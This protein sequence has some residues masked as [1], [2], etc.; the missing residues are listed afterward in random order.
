MRLFRA[1]ASILFSRV[2]Q[3]LANAAVVIMVAKTLGP[4]GQGHYSL[5]VAA[6][7]LLA[8]V[9]GGGM[10]LAAVP[11]LRQDKIPPGRMMRAQ[12]TWVA[13][14]WSGPASAWPGRAPAGSGPFLATHLGWTPGWGYLAALAAAGILAFEIFSYDLLARGTPGHRGGRQRLAGH[15][16]PGLVMIIGGWAP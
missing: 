8:S 5:T 2:G 7:L 14:A 4:V 16:T 15:G 13:G 3:V 11:P 9:L 10:G 6:V 1:G 12:L